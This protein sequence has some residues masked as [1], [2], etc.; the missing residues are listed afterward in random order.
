MTND[1]RNT[2]AFPH[3]IEYDSEHSRARL[4]CSAGRGGGSGDG[5]SNT[6]D[7]EGVGGGVAARWAAPLQAAL[8][9]CTL[10]DTA[11]T[12]LQYVRSRHGHSLAQ[13]KKVW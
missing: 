13:W 4:R 8:D 1:V 11:E 3:S 10:F 2:V 7:Q 9:S 12:S 6:D 5:G